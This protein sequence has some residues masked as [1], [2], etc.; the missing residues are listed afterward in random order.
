MSRLDPGQRHSRSHPCPLCGGYQSGV[1]ASHCFGFIL[2]DGKGIACTQ[3]PSSVEVRDT[4]GWIHF[5]DGRCSCGE[6]HDG[7]SAQPARPPRP[8]K[9]YPRREYLPRNIKV[10]G[11]NGAWEN[12]TFAGEWEFHHPDGTLA[13]VE[14]RYERP[15]TRN[16]H[17]G[18]ALKTSRPFTPRPDGS[19]VM[20]LE[21]EPLFYNLPALLSAPID[22]PVYVVEGPRKA[23]ILQ[24][25][26]RAAGAVGVVTSA[27][28]APQRV[29]M[30]PLA[31]RRI[32]PTLDNDAAGERYAAIVGQRALEA[33]AAQVC[34]LRLADHMPD[35]P[36]AGDVVEYLAAGHDGA[37][38]ARLANAAPVYIPTTCQDCGHSVSRD[39]DDLLCYTCGARRHLPMIAPALPPTTSPA[40]TPPASD[41]S[42]VTGG[43]RAAIADVAAEVAAVATTLA[44]TRDPSAAKVIDLAHARYGKDAIE[45]RM[46]TRTVSA[47]PAD[48][49]SRKAG[50]FLVA[51]NRTRREVGRKAHGQGD[52]QSLINMGT[53]AR[54]AM[55]PP[56][57]AHVYRKELEEAGIILTTP[58]MMRSEKGLPYTLYAVTDGPNAQIQW[59]GDD[60][61]VAGVNLPQRPER[62]SQ[63]R[64]D[65]VPIAELIPELAAARFAGVRDLDMARITLASQYEAADGEYLK[66]IRDALQSVG[67]MKTDLWKAYLDARGIPYQTALHRIQR[68]ARRNM[69]NTRDNANLALSENENPGNFGTPEGGQK[70][71]PV[72]ESR[73]PEDPHT[74]LTTPALLTS[75]GFS[76]TPPP[77]YCPTC[78]RVA[79]TFYSSPNVLR[80][81]QDH[82]IPQSGP[83]PT[84]PPD[85][86]LR[87]L[88]AGQRPMEGVS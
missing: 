69:C 9:T 49:L 42:G 25:A 34:I 30:D 27:K 63:T 26:L 12:Y 2:R 46:L 3:R 61:R 85:Y 72:D 75:H 50:A 51:L 83:P 54:E 33:G 88:F 16:E 5:L 86:D 52:A 56:G 44:A 41:E 22:A 79:P 66:K 18:K 67:G 60:G 28:T 53:V 57:Q 65:H 37:D 82:V 35:L 15:D 78:V 64:K 47:I 45:D 10:E 21:C 74:Q 1:G 48:R 58:E 84:S 6:P 31:G 71:T 62:P 13:Y 77:T 73:P 81:D 23:D 17:G 80:C 32:I 14:R 4:G 59:G 11:E 7:V 87:T 68:A 20:A 43:E 36:S 40:T 39:G 19:W 55:L 24:A 70:N 38:L 8:P 76:T 29:A